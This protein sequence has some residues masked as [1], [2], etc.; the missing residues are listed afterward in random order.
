V[1]RAV[2]GDSRRSDSA[3]RGLQGQE[4]RKALGVCCSC[5]RKKNDECC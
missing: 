1:I 4:S 2:D 5:C 3:P